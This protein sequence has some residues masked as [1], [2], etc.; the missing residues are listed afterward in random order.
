MN[1]LENV[2]VSDNEENKHNDRS[3]IV[4]KQLPSA[5]DVAC[6]QHKC[7]LFLSLHVFDLA[8]ISL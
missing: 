1:N 8:T 5:F 2:L 6:H 3:S 4:T 7:A